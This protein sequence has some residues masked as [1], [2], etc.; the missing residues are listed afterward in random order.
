MA[1][2]LGFEVEADCKEVRVTV[3]GHI[4]RGGT[5]TAYDRVLAAVRRQR[6]RRRPCRRVRNH[7][8][9]SGR[10]SVGYRWPTR[11]GELKL[12]PQSRYDDAAAFFG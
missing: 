8:L 5:P 11:S 9:A 12:V 2:Q 4:Q 3:L 1:Q 10:T 7:G 6:R